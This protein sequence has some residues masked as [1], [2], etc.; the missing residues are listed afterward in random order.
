MSVIRNIRVSI[1]KIENSTNQFRRTATAPIGDCSINIRA[2]QDWI[3]TG[4][5]RNNTL[6]AIRLQR[7]SNDGTKG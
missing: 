1:P 2:N 7:N 3:V 4:E 5:Y 6:C